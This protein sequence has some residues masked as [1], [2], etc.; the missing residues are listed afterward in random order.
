MPNI[1]TPLTFFQKTR[2]VWLALFA[3]QAFI[4]E[5]EADNIRLNAA[6]TVT[7]VNCGVYKVRSGIR[8]ALLWGSLAMI[9][10]FLVG[11][12]VGA[13]VGAALKFAIGI[14]VLGTTILLWASLAVQGWNIQTA[15]GV[16][17]SERLNQWVFR[18]LYFLGTVLISAGSVWSLF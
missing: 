15:D 4:R 12:V 7:D 11:A 18:T 5:E 16:T 6:A 10:G 2:L 1:G 8:Q 13:A 3:P 9:L 17:L 14:V